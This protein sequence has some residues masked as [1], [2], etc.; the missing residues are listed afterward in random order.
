M[1]TLEI[2]RYLMAGLHGARLNNTPLAKRAEMHAQQARDE[3]EQ[4]GGVYVIGNEPTARLRGRN[5]PKLQEA[6][7]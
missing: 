7:Q 5:K 6:D 1:K 4:H 2:W 3:A